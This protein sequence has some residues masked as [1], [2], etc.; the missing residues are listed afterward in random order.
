[1]ASTSIQ[2]IT[3]PNGLKIYW[4]GKDRIYVHAKSEFKNEVHGLCGTF[5]HR[6]ESTFNQF[7]L[8]SKYKFFVQFRIN[9][10]TPH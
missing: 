4:N 10:S 7:D 3:L 9:P 5:N 2:T 1:M 8:I 6:Q